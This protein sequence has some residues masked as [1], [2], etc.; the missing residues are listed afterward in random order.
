[1]TTSQIAEILGGRVEGDPNLELAGFAPA[2]TARAGDLTFAENETYLAAAENS[3]ATAILVGPD[4]PGSQRTLIRVAQ[5]RIA[6][7]KVLPLFFP[8]PRHPAGIHPSAVVAPTAAIDPSA[9]IGPHCVVGE[10]CRI[11]ARTVLLGGNHI[12]ADCTLG[13]DC[14]LFPNAVIYT[15]AQIGNRVRLHSCCVI[16]SDGYGYVFDHG[17]H[18]KV[19]QV[20]TVIIH[21]DVEIGANTS[22]DRGALGATVIGKGTKIDNLVQIAHNVVIGEHCLIV[23][24]V[25]IAGSTRLG[26]FVTLAGQVGIAG[27]L[28]IGSRVSIGA[29]SGVMHPIPDGE[30]WLGS[31]AVPEKQAKRQYIAIYRLP[32]LTRQVDQLERRLQILESAASPS[33]NATLPAVE[34]TEG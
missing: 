27:H 21:D 34:P 2:H 5:P 25:G 10:R 15:R 32:E 24:Q 29:Q 23:A 17:A 9:H 7:A 28:K 19:P 6:F 33:P 11:G 22:I 31:P 26:N 14:V 13:D 1:M 3:A 20:G 4:L 12:A 18:L 16:G 30:K 8:E